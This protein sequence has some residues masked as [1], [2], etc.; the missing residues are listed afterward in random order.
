MWLEG[1]P[2]SCQAVAELQHLLLRILTGPNAGAEAR[3]SGKT[4]I[5]SSSA[6]DITISDPELAAEHFALQVDGDAVVIMVG[7]APVTIGGES[8]SNGTFRIALFDLIKFGTTCCAVGR[9]GAAWPAFSPADLLPPAP[10]APPPET[11]PA[12]ETPAP[13]AAAAPV[14]AQAPPAPPR[15]TRQPVLAIAAVVIVLLLLGGGYALLAGFGSGAIATVK[16]TTAQDIVTAQQ[17]HGVTIRPDG[18]EGVV[19]EGFVPSG[20]QQRRL[21]QALLDA[22]IPIKYRVVSLEQQ[23]SAVRT[24]VAAAGAPLAV[25]AD[26]KSGKII[27]DGFLPEMTHIDTLLRVLRRDIADLRPIETRI[28][29]PAM[30]RDGVRARLAEAGLDGLTNVEMKGQAARITGALS[31]EGRAATRRIAEDLTKRW[32]PMV[33]VEDATTIAA[34][35]PAP[36]PVEPAPAPAP[37]PAP[38]TEA[39][40]IRSSAPPAKIVIIVGGKDGF[41]RDDAGRRYEIGDKLANGEVIE[42]IRVEEIV[43]SRDGVKYRYTFGGGR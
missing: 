12:E 40:T 28:V 8:R 1:A 4:I 6:A 10:P 15:R 37:A 33:K 25:E 38:K 39:V 19:A 41:V 27:L 34:M 22:E 30:V 23:V 21:R 36:V 29:T 32:S 35:A 18:R 42:E 17:A 7:D 31:D 26:E 20:E 2:P 5:G 13:E 3:L 24:I 16:G 14:E 43:T 9:E 11:P